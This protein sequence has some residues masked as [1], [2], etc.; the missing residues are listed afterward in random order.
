[1]SP[2]EIYS[3]LSFP[4]YAQKLWVNSRNDTNWYGKGEAGSGAQRPIPPPL[5]LAPARSH[6]ERREE[7]HK[8]LYQLENTKYNLQTFILVETCI[9]DNVNWD[10]EIVT[11]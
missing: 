7:S 1:V 5:P 4:H 2:G 8:Y 6:S 11:H 10:K 9:G 3:T